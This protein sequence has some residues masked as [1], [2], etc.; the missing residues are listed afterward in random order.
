MDDALEAVATELGLPQ[1]RVP[2][3]R[4]SAQ[5]AAQHAATT[6]H[7]HPPDGGT[8][9]FTPPPQHRRPAPPAGDETADQVETESAF[10]ERPGPTRQFAGIDLEEFAWARQRGRR[11]V[12]LWVL[13]VLVINALVAGGAWTLGLNINGLI[14]R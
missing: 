6:A 8:R 1:F 10:D 9:Q 14:G 5:H 4:T 3:P 12:V 11:A 7:H 2:A 13:A